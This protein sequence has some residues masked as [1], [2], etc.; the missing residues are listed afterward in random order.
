MNQNSPRGFQGRGK[1]KPKE[2]LFRINEF[3]KSDVVR[4]VGDDIESKVMGLREALDLADSL[5]LDLVEINST[6][7]PIICRVCDYS[8]FLYEKKKKDKEKRLSNKHTLKEVKLG[9]H[10]QEHDIAFKLKN[11][12]KFLEEGD[13]VKAYIQF[14]GR[15]IMYK[16]QGEIILLKFLESLQDIG[17]PES[18]PKLEGRSMFV[19][20]TPKA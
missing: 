1:F 10:I 13:K 9:A 3:I 6:S 2:P 5:N 16:E 17:K 19:I 11:T 20:I 14:R 18:L 12:R 4:V 8:K 15:E 7:N